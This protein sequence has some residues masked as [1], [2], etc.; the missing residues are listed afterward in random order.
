[1]LQSV[2]SQRRETYMFA[3]Y[4]HRKCN[5]LRAGNQQLDN[6]EPF[7]R[8]L[9][10]ILEGKPKCCKVS[11]VKGE[12][13]AFSFSNTENILFSGLVINQTFSKFDP[14]KKTEMLQSVSS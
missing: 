13:H 9:N 5:F 12:K 1:M 2:S 8:F 11:V 10:L 6:F 3:V 14:G 4:K 7:K